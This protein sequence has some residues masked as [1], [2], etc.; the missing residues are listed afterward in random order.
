MRLLYVIDSLAPGGA[1]TSL[2]AMAPGLVRRGIDLH[3]LPLGSRRDLARDLEAA[4]ATVH[5]RT[6][7]P[8]RLASIQTVLDVAREV[9]PDL[10]HTTLYESDVTGRIAARILRIP[11]S[12]SIVNDS[13]GAAHYRES[14]RTKLH[15]ARALDAATSIFAIRFHSITAAIA[16]NVG[17]R[18]GIPRDKITVIPR[19]RDPEKYPFRSPEVRQ[20]VREDLQ[21]PEGAPVVLS[22]ARH[23]PQKGLH[24]LLEA[25]SH[26]ASNH[27]SVVVLL[28]GKEGRSSGALQAQAQDIEADIRFL[29]HRTDIA[30]LLA[31]SDVFCFPSEREGFGGVLI[32]AMAVGCPIVASA[33]PTSLEVLGPGDDACAMLTPVADPP[34]IARAIDTLLTDPPLAG[35]LARTGRERFDRQ[36]A[37]HSVTDKMADF[38]IK[39]AT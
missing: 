36:Y 38:F 4:G 6:R 23:E 29:G 15:T 17:S 25:T 27:P 32:E 26:L 9:R 22:V 7:R 3:V 24:H 2:V 28:A 11:T 39:A 14:N 37:I 20:R 5:A 18:L 35:R 12:T 21:I 10:I 13:Y 19:G 1:E 33:I 16:D 30:E 8:G 31:A 34:D